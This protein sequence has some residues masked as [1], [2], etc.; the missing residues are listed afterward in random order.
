MLGNLTTWRTRV[1]WCG[2]A[3]LPHLAGQ[4]DLQSA[5]RIS[6]EAIG[7][8]PLQMS[9]QGFELVT[10]EQTVSEPQL[11]LAA[12]GAYQFADRLL[13]CDATTFSSTTLSLKADALRLAM[14]PS[15][16]VTGRVHFRGDLEKLWQRFG[17]TS[18]GR[19]QGHWTGQ[20][21]LASSAQGTSVRATTRVEGF[22]WQTRSAPLAQV[23]SDAYRTLWHEPAAQLD[24]NGYWAGDVRRWQIA[25][26]LFQTNSFGIQLA[27]LVTPT[28]STVHVDLQGSSSLNLDELSLRLRPWLGPSIQLS[29]SS[30]TPFR[31]KGPLTPTSPGAR[32]PVQAVEQ[33]VS[34]RVALVPPEL[35][36]EFGVGWQSARAYGIVAGAGSLTARLQQQTVLVQPLQVPVSQGRLRLAPQIELLSPYRVRLEPGSVLD[37]VA[38]T[39]EMCHSWLKYLAPLVADATSAEGL[40]SVRVARAELPLAAPG[41]A[42]VGGSL[43]IHQ[44]HVGPGPL[45][46]QMLGLASSIRAIVD[47]NGSRGL[48]DT[49]ARWIELPQQ[50]VSFRVEGGHVAHQ[51]LTMQVGDVTIR[52]RGSVG[53]NERLALVAEVPVLDNWVASR[54][55][56]AGLRGQTIKV[57]I[58]GTLQQPTID[59]RALQQLAQ[60]TLRGATEG[61]LQ[62]QLKQLLK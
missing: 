39:P 5:A 24:L 54:P 30:A 58:R 53:F 46:R 15:L 22:Q 48:L 9:V 36:G 17:A 41:R 32:P 52:T 44:G 20:A 33:A 38:I 34:N 13:V 59:Q 3:R 25:D 6:R 1:A 37:Q 57:P 43:T 23:R 45:A 60:Q 21:E 27:G 51:D 49:K 50:V 61:L 11:T 29:G 8:D 40:F 19:M 7:L 31:L 18:N 56:L 55:Y 35:E 26:G 47:P 28:P 14:Q 12:R 4:I 16:S 10:A 62:Q 42:E 2:L